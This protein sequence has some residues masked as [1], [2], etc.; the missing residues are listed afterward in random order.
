M[1]Y[2]ETIPINKEEHEMKIE[3]TVHNCITNEGKDRLVVVEGI[4]AAD[5]LKVLKDILGFIPTSLPFFAKQC[6]CTITT[7]EGDK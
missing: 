3:Y 2:C 6:N 4:R 7:I 5:M 1:I